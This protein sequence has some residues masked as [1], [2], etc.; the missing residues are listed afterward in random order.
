MADIDVRAHAIAIR[1]ANFGHRRRKVSRLRLPPVHAD[2]LDG[3]LD[4]AA[5]RPRRVHGEE[6]RDEAEQ[7]H[8]AHGQDGQYGP[9][10]E[11]G[12]RPQSTLPIVPFRR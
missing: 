2:H 10:V 1:G 9:A 11:L 7:H 8:H 3:D 12:R 4:P 5:R 6:D